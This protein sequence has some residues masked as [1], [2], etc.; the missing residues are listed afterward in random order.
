MIFLISL[1]NKHFHS[2][3]FKYVNIS[4]LNIT[5]YFC[6]PIQIRHEPLL[7]KRR[8][9]KAPLSKIQTNQHHK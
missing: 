8:K 9:M 3:I 4:I 7:K 1:I 6:P 2:N 5:L